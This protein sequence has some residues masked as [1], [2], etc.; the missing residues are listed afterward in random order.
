MNICKV[1]SSAAGDEDLASGLRIPLKQKNA[2]IALPGHS[3]AHQ[4]RGPAA[5]HNHIEFRFLF[6]HSCI[7]ADCTDAQA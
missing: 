6:S 3:R 2:S 7:V 4:P 5:E 1:A